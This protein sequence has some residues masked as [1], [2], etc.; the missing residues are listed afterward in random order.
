VST[1]SAPDSP[2]AP[3]SAPPTRP[4]AGAAAGAGAAG[5]SPA[6]RATLAAVVARVLDGRLDLAPELDAAALVE[7][8]LMRAPAHTR[9]DVARVLDVFG[10]RAAA[11]LTLGVGRPFAAL[12]PARQDRMLW[13]W[14]R[15]RVPVQRTVHQALRRLT[16]SV[17]Y[18]HP[19]V[20]AAVG[21][22]GPLHRRPPAVSWEVRPPA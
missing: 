19:A 14:A 20:Q 15:S 4:A 16:L 2:L 9:A 18:G 8:R 22:R 1:L 5:L 17:W 10:S 3:P 11:C 12:D 13:R 6:R 7:A 21:H